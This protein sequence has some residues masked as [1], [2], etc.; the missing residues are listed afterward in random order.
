MRIVTTLFATAC[1]SLGCASTVSANAEIRFGT[2]EIFKRQGSQVL[3]AKVSS[4]SD[5]EAYSDNLAE[6]CLQDPS[7]AYRFNTKPL[8]GDWQFDISPISVSSSGGP[9]GG[10]DNDGGGWQ[11]FT[12]IRFQ[13]NKPDEKSDNGY[14]TLTMR[15]TLRSVNDV[16]DESAKVSIWERDAEDLEQEI[17]NFYIDYKYTAGDKCTFKP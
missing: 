6:L 16:R 14:Q 3:Y 2:S 17:K 4:N 15:V 13:L 8:S 5:P 1:F 9:V 7:G 12:S 11:R 10:W